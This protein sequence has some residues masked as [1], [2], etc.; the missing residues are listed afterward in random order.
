MYGSNLWDLFSVAA[1]KLFV[2]WNVMIRT[3]FNLPF[4][5]HR[6]LLYNLTDIPHLRVALIKR[7]VKFYKKLQLCVKPEIVH[8]FYLQKSNLRSVFGSNCSKICNKCNVADVNFVKSDHI[9]MPIQICEDQ[10]WRI[11]LLLNLTELRDNGS[12]DIPVADIIDMINF[13]CCD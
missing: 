11:P 6:Y 2:S 9:S 3:T 7:F 4:A 12:T 5:T 8:L 1:D 10:K 13:I